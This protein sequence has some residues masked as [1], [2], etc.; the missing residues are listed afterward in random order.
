MALFLTGGVGF[1]Y[2]GISE[3]AAQLPTKFEI[4]A[5]L[6]DEI[7][8]AEATEAQLRL[9]RIPH[10]ASVILVPRADAWETFKKQNPDY[11]TTGID[12]PLPDSV[13][14][15]LSDVEKSEEVVAAIQKDPSVAKDGVVYLKKE[16]DLVAQT[17]SFL[18]LIGL[19]LG[20]L[21]LATSGVLIY[22]AIR[23][24]IVSRRREFRIM[25][26][27]G[28]TRSTIVVPLLIEGVIQGVAGGFLAS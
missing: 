24:T 19:A 23:M 9:K 28:A 4:R 2:K 17:L 16:R 18:R 10:T 7:K 12:N 3:Y 13:T 1:A 21:M 15:T 20:G 11:P 8:P 22:N 5:F 6:K 14:V 26:L 25:E 27:V